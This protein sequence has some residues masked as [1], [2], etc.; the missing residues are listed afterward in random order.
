MVRFVRQSIVVTVVTVMCMP[1]FAHAMSLGDLNARV[2]ELLAQLFTLKAQVDK[3]VEQKYAT[4]TPQT[5]P[6]VITKS[7]LSC[8]YL[9][10]NLSFAFPEGF[11]FEKVVFGT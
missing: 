2:A 3:Q 6:Q 11:K 10:R 8:L 7:D 5:K 4:T 1:I 9:P